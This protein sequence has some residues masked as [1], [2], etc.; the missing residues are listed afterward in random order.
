MRFV[1]VQYDA[2]NRQF[3]LMDGELASQLEDHGTYLI[4]DFPTLD[5]LPDLELL[6]TDHLPA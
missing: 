4:A 5:F 1:R 6:D 3:D 2:Y